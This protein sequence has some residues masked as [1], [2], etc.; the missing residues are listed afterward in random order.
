MSGD[1]GLLFLDD[2]IHTVVGVEVGLDVAED[3]N[4]SVG[5][6][7]TRSRMRNYNTNEFRNVNVPESASCRRSW[8]ETDGIVE[9]Q[10]Q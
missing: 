2:L 7:A 3:N 9:R 10:T 5:T 6:S 1:E 8:R 4:G